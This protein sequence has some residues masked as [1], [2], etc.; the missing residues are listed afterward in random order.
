MLFRST[1]GC[2]GFWT[3]AIA[4]QTSRSI[5][6]VAA[7]D[8]PCGNYMHAP[9]SSFFPPVRTVSALQRSKPWLL[10]FRS[11]WA[12][13]ALRVKSSHPAT[14]VGSFRR[15]NAPLTK[16]SSLRGPRASHSAPWEREPGWSN[17]AATAIEGIKGSLS[18]E[19]S[20]TLSRFTDRPLL[21]RSPPVDQ[22]L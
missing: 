18:L 8:E 7:D 12:M 19:L 17:F 10:D 20:P 4:S 1:F 13:S 11:S 16:L 5:C 9:I 15:R 2:P 3:A 14:R 6:A 21:D 22:V